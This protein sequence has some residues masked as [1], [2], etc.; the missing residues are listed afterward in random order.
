MVTKNG[1]RS[2]KVQYRNAKGQDRR[3]TIPFARPLNDAR[4]EARAIFGEVAKGRDP[5]EEER[6]A[7]KTDANTLQAVAEEYLA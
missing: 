6:Q 5:L 3:I 2:Y 4:K 1:A 7:R